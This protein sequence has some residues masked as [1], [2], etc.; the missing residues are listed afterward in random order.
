MAPFSSGYAAADPS[1]WA[2]FRAE[3]NRVHAD[4]WTEFDASCRDH[5]A[6][7]LLPAY[8]FRDEELTGAIDALLADTAL[9]ERMAGIAARMQGARVPSGRRNSSSRSRQRA[10]RSS[11]RSQPKREAARFRPRQADS[12][13]AEGPVLGLGGARRDATGLGA[14]DI[15]R[16]HG[17]VEDVTLQ[18]APGTAAF[19]RRASPAGS[20]VGTLA[21]GLAIT[22]MD[23]GP[24]LHRIAGCH[25]LPVTT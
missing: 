20:P 16:S 24:G 8:A 12:M 14:R 11:A 4:S 6:P 23:V 15:G 25:G 7:G 9:R 3:Y 19:R 13:R 1:R 17:R 2:I 18:C 5:G 21:S 22:R 10:R